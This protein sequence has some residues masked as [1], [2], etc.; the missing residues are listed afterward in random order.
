MENR[1]SGKRPE[2]ISDEEINLTDNEPAQELC[3]QVRILTVEAREALLQQALAVSN[4]K[5]NGLI[6]R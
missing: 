4:E 2:P 5:C 1:I 6:K 3:E